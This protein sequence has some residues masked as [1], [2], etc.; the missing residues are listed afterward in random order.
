MDREGFEVLS[1][2][3]SIGE[4]KIQY[5][6]SKKQEYKNMIQKLFKNPIACRQYHDAARDVTNDFRLVE[7]YKKEITTDIFVDLLR[8]EVELLN[9]G[10][11]D[12]WEYFTPFVTFAHESPNL[13]QNVN[14]HMALIW[15]EMKP[16]L[17]KLN[18]TK[19][20]ILLE[21]YYGH[22][23]FSIIKFAPFMV[24]D[25]YAFDY[26]IDEKE[27]GDEDE[28]EDKDSNDTDADKLYVNTK[29]MWDAQDEKQLMVSILEG[30]RECR[31]VHKYGKDLV[32][33]LAWS[34]NKHIMELFIADDY[35]RYTPV[36]SDYDVYLKH[37][38]MYRR[39][40]SQNFPELN[41]RILYGGEHGELRCIEDVMRYA[42]MSGNL[43]L[44][45]SFITEYQIELR[46]VGYNPESR[47]EDDI[48]HGLHIH[49][50]QARIVEYLR[51]IESI[52]ECV[53]PLYVSITA[54][55]AKV[56]PSS[57]GLVNLNCELCP[58]CESDI[59]L[60]EQIAAKL[61][62]KLNP[63]L[64]NVAANLVEHH[65]VLRADILEYSLNKLKNNEQ[66]ARRF[67]GVF[68]QGAKVGK[69]REEYMEILRTHPTTK[70]INVFVC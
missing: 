41:V 1:S 5:A 11:F 29:E 45:K 58:K 70:N 28:N 18:L 7:D 10:M 25:E 54:E 51:E 27:D 63:D 36:V 38:T 32:N 53:D 14:Y 47:Y 13:N 68:A 39:K 9:E 60:M 19:C 64:M 56:V 16:C 35:T 61:G 37:A 20:L 65:D 22:D 50:N 43:P 48:P 23:I 26:I 67:V 49:H 2:Y 31:S 66:M 15:Q 21:G 59:G 42:T 33:M 40:I 17:H 24:K 4:N 55:F 34:P 8:V 52:I 69:Y 44:L 46:I 62:E 30:G 12:S 6:I 3:L 57:L